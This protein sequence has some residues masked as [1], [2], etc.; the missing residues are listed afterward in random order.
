MRSCIWTYLRP[1][2]PVK[3]ESSGGKLLPGLT[4]S[5][6]AYPL[7]HCDCADRIIDGHRS[8]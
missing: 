6:G 7:C 2:L 8:F 4:M 3:S 5:Q 1:L